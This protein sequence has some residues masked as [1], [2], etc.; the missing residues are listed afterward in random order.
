MLAP[1]VA[2]RVTIFLVG[3]LFKRKV[4]WSGQNRDAY[5]LSWGDAARG[6][7]PQTLF[8]LTLGGSIAV[9]AGLSTVAWAS[10]MIAGLALS[11]PFAVLTAHPA[12]GAW[13]GRA[14][15]CAIPDERTAAPVLARAGAAG[16]PPARE[17]EPRRA[18]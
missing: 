1:A 18:A 8:G 11:I 12:V 5:R 10:P 13:A 14:G 3:L 15:L 16:P 7:W 17:A 9:F 2:L 4:A 6:L